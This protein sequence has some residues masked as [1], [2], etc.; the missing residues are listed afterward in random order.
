MAVRLVRSLLLWPCVIA[1]ALSCSDPAD[2]DGRLVCSTTG[3][4]DIA[5]CA[6]L[7]GQVVDTGGQP[8]TDVQVGFTALRPC[9]CNEFFFQVGT[10]GEFRQTVSQF[11]AGSVPNSDTVTVMVRASATG[12]QYPQPTITD[13]A[14]AVLT[15][16][17]K[18]ELPVVT[19]VQIRLAIP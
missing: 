2:E 9:N 4:F 5:G 12:S 8:L 19:F 17:P 18:G 11:P 13:S 7:A 6:V 10:N 14:P 15:F 1:V 16:R 3:E